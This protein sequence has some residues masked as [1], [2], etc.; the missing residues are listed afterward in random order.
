MARRL[1]A[2]LIEQ[3]DFSLGEVDEI[4]NTNTMQ[5]GFLQVLKKCR[6]CHITD[7][8]IVEKR[9]AFAL[10]NDQGILPTD[11]GG[12]NVFEQ[13]SFQ[14][15]DGDWYLVLTILNGS[16]TD[17]QL[18][19]FA[20]DQT[21]G[22]RLPIE[23]FTLATAFTGLVPSQIDTTATDNYIVF[24]S[25]TLTPQRLIIDEVTLSNSV[26]EPITFSVLPSLD[27][28]ELEYSTYTFSP[29]CDNIETL[30]SGNPLTCSILD[31]FGSTIN[32][33]RPNAG[34]P[35][36]T[37]EWIG[38]L[39]AGQTGTSSEQPIGF[40][41]I[42]NITDKD[43]VTQIF[44]VSVLQQFGTTNYSQEGASWSV[45]EPAWSTEKGFPSKTTFFQ[46]RLW[47]AN[48]PHFPMFIAGSN[49]NT[50]N[51]FNTANGNST[52]AIAY[53]LK[54]SE[55]GG[56][57]S[58]FGGQNLHINT[59]SQ[60]LAVTAGQDVGIE[61]GN[62]SPKL[63]SSYTTSAIKPISYRSNI[64]F[65][66]VDGKALVQVVD[67]IQEVQS[68]II[69]F[70]SQ[71]LIR[72]PI[73]F[74]VHVVADTQD[75]FL[76]L[77][78]SDNT[79]TVYSQG[80]LT[81][82][83]GFSLYEIDLFPTEE[84]RQLTVIDNTLY[85][86]TN[87]FRLLYMSTRKDYD[88]WEELSMTSGIID[89]SNNPMYSVG[90]S[91]SVSYEL[92]VQGVMNDFYLGEFIVFDSG[93]LK[94]DVLQDITATVHIGSKY[95][96]L[97]QPLSLYS[98]PTGSLKLRRVSQAFVQFFQSYSLLINGKQFA[99]LSPS[100][101]LPKGTIKLSVTG[102]ARLGYSQG[103]KNNFE[104]VVSQSAPYDFKIQ[105]LAWSINESIIA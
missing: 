93:G 29:F 38:G 77:L 76:T 84:I 100:E 42:T 60:Q 94:L 87:K 5:P 26:I 82:V 80:L 43:A 1:L 34:D 46:G 98:G 49:I 78:N 65:T 89:V 63:I 68:A 104:L 73:S 9:G 99:T 30:P 59:A 50:P 44:T 75:Q 95:I 92:T 12:N 22:V 83:S 3:S 96:P 4:F 72:N 20:F 91:V 88:G 28:G 2:S 35:K 62:F 39:I 64:F 8:K 16:D 54:N 55:N 53:I 6:N 71:N 19:K 31:V 86:V 52:D 57:T 58:I 102:T 51:T 15:R 74:A 32:V 79:I 90:D 56:I 40:G 103:S 97:I 85:I 69:S 81:G 24:A 47:F 27:F 45:K 67:N 18:I 11:V 48:V 33:T 25:P 17:V 10:F 105:S 13:L 101:L 36:F 37:N 14:S 61:P 21:A 66:T 23:S 70:N 41:I 7:Q